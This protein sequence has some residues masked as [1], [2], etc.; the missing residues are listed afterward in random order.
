MGSSLAHLGGGNE[1]VFSLKVL[2][3]DRRYINTLCR[4]SHCFPL[5]S[6]LKVQIISTLTQ[7][8]ADHSEAQRVRS[9]WL[10]RKRHMPAREV[11]IDGRKIHAVFQSCSNSTN[12]LHN[13]VMHVT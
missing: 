7:G 6:W 12:D 11:E 3:H 4:L 8:A 5:G 1:S 13:L 9:V 2:I 10:S